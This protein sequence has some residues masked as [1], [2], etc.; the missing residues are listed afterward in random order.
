MILMESHN[1]PTRKKEAYSD[2]HDEGNTA[3]DV[4]EIHGGRKRWGEG[5]VTEVKKGLTEEETLEQPQNG[6][7]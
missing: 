4:T 6:R 1:I 3:V 7:I 2:K 5:L